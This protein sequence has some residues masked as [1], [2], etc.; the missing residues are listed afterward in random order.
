MSTIFGLYHIDQKP[1]EQSDALS[2]QSAMMH[3]KT[4]D[5]GLFVDDG[6]ILGHLMLHN[7][8]ESFNEKLPLA[9]EENIITADCR[10]DNREEIIKLL[11]D[12]PFVSSE[13][14]DSLLILLLYKKF[15][16]DCLKYIIGDFAFAIYSKITKR[17][18]CARDHL[19]VKPFFYYLVNGV[20]VFATEKRGILA[21]R[22]LNKEIN[23]KF[24]YQLMA[25]IEPELT[26]TFY[27]HIFC[28]RPGHKMILE[29]GDIKIDTYWKISIPEI[30]KL[31][32]EQDYHEAF[33]F[34]M[35]RAV[36]CR[37]R[38]S[39]PV[40][41]ELSGGLDSS[42]VTGF[43]ARLLEDKKKLFTFSNVLPIN[44]NGE[45]EYEDEEKYIDEI[46]AYNGITNVIKNR[47]GH[48][49][50]FLEPHKIALEVNSGVEIYTAWWQEPLRKEMEKRGIRVTL[51]GFPGDE[52]IS[53]SGSFYFHDLIRE[54]KYAEFLK[55]AIRKKQYSLPVRKFVGH[56]LP[57][58]VLGSIRNSRVEKKKGGH[59]LSDPVIAKELLLETEKNQPPHPESF[60]AYIAA[61]VTREHTTLRMQSESSFCIRHRLEPRYPLADIRLLNFFLSLPSSVLGHPQ[62]NRYFFRKSMEN[63]IPDNIRLR[64]DKTVAPLIYYWIEN[65]KYADDFYHWATEKRKFAQNPV[66]K[67]LDI[68]KVIKGY[69]PRNKDNYQDAKFNPRR[70]FE[71][72]QILLFFSSAEQ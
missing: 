49:D 40:A 30:L 36:K 31:K 65:R 13:V 44:V 18:F 2:M 51:S 62:I 68:E 34:E 17:I 15:G 25:N 8:P 33:R 20:F 6:I 11:V 19:G 71:M 7:T 10:L 37:L 58:F 1:V 35:S 70:P 56:F 14:A 16:T 32:S 27:K 67:K 24:I 12:F 4:D 64:N 29:N 60:K 45:K 9:L 48:W 26:Q 72:E 54:G 43:A 3:W 69:D 50:N 39:F 23:E 21:I 47:D 61:R 28:L 38:T 53:N 52:A 46:I 5:S 57:D 59:F 63:I 42:A 22:N 55:V 41:T 66:L